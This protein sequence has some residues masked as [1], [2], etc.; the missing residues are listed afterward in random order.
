VTAHPRFRRPAL[1]GGE[2]LFSEDVFVTRPVLPDPEAFSRRTAGLFESHWLTNAG[3]LACELEERVAEQ[4]G[5]PRCATFSS[6]TT[7]LLTALR[8]LELEGEVITT[9][10][11]FPATPHC[12]EWN[13][14][15]PVFA[16]IDPDTY[17][18]DPARVEER[19]GPRTSAILPV[20]VFGN[21]CD[22]EAF[23]G[24][25]ERHDVKIVYDAAHCFGVRHHDRPIGAYGDCSAL[26]FHATKVF[27]TAEGGAVMTPDPALHER[28][29]LLRNF[30]I[31]SEDE[32]RGVG[33]NGKLS[34]LHAAMG[35]LVLEEIDAEI[36]RRARLSALYCES[37]GEL[38]GVR[39]QR[40]ADDTVRNYFNF[41]IEIEA[42]AFGL[43]RD[44]V[45]RALRAEHVV[46]R[47]YFHPLCT[48]NA[49][50]ADLPSASPGALPHA[51]RL[52]SRILS[53]PLYGELGEEAVLGIAEVVAALH[54]DAPA[55]RQ[56]LSGVAQ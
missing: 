33:L 15:T 3:P 50:Y 28:L 20:H 44:E 6:G 7:A 35:L 42:D 55:L 52:S 54:R 18:L 16:D 48:E 49:C 22:V 19:I 17:C 53:L 43:S 37:L 5:V 21:P 34:E 41:T 39:L 40:F 46:A 36:A 30:G 13:G 2:P 47:K 4:L 9:P 11:T 51:E 32:V 25:A 26:S 38:P 31:V 56:A 45:H 1:L 29:T 8:A 12:I 10:F 27:H 23:A 14:L 24:I